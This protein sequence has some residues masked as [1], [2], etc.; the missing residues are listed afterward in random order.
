M[1][2][3]KS[4]KKTCFLRRGREH[5]GKWFKKLKEKPILTHV[6]IAIG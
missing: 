6:T 3:V 2:T 5:N 1:C 4:F